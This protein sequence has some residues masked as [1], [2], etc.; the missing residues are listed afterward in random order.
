MGVGTSAL[1][2]KYTEENV[3][4]FARR[5]PDGDMKFA[6]QMI[7]T[8]VYVGEKQDF[9][10]PVVTCGADGCDVGVAWDGFLIVI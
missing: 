10:V 3:I 4:S 9:P 8:A 5:F 1:C 7:R 2:M 6:E